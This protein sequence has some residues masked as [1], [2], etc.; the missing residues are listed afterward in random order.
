MSSLY[1]FH[2]LCTDYL[3]YNIMEEYKI[4]KLQLI[5]LSGLQ[6]TKEIK[7]HKSVRCS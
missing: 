5:T 2:C 3:G 4:V 6:Q 1:R 7:V